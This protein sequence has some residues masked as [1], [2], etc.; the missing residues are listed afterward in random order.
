MNKIS[1]KLFILLFFGM[2]SSFLY[3]QPSKIWAFPPKFNFFYILER[4]VNIY[5]QPN[6]NSRITGQLS[7]ND[8]IYITERTDTVQEIDNVWGYWYK[9]RKD[10]MEGYIFGGYI[11]VSF[12][13]NR[14]DI[15]GNGIYDYVY[16]RI[17]NFDG[18]YWELDGINDIFIYINGTRIS[19][20][21]LKNN[22]YGKWNGCSFALSETDGTVLIILQERA[23]PGTYYYY[24]RINKNRTI[25]FEEKTWID[26]TGLEDL[27]KIYHF[28]IEDIE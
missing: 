4:S 16:S 13:E 19:T 25:Q 14:I 6:L 10:K 12:F 15:D 5:S 17:S 28:H 2:F 20:D 26:F 24:F 1:G 23:P 3:A 22:R 9:I 8:K 21:V 7:L 11:A 27:E 18:V